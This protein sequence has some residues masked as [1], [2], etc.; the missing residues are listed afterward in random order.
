MY[1][2]IS[3]RINEKF[4]YYM[5]YEYLND[6]IL[7]GQWPTEDKLKLLSATRKLNRKEAEKQILRIEIVK[8]KHSNI[9]TSYIGERQIQKQKIKEQ[10]HELVGE[11]ENPLIMQVIN[12]YYLN[13]ENVKKA[14]KAKKDEKTK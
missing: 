9:F 11:W 1:K 10:M 7:Y 2:P 14:K 8:S 4:I 6:F 12:N 13:Q 3:T 5:G